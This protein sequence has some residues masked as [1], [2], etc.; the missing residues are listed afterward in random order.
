MRFIP[1]ADAALIPNIIVDGAPAQGTVMT[2]SHWPKSGTPPR[3][4]ADSSA[5]IVFKY[6]ETP[7]A[8]VEV[9]DV[10]NNHFDEDGLVGIFALTLPDLAMRSK[11]LLIDA[12]RAGDFGI[13]RIRD[14]ARVAFVLGAYSEAASS[15]LPRETFDGPYADVA[16]RLYEHILSVL[17]RLITHIG[18]FETFWIDEDRVL[19][20]SESALDRGIVTIEPHDDLD[21]AI[22]GVPEDVAVPHVM[23]LNT[24]TPHT[25][26]IVVRGGSVELRYRYEGWVQF[27]SKKVAPRVDLTALAAELTAEEQKGS[28]IFE[29]VANITPR[30]YFDRPHTSLRVESVVARMIDALRSGASAWDP[31]D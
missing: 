19:D 14:A 29:G 8:H 22:V 28:W 24:R 20:E 16:A 6:L 3:L 25:R 4:R 5:E 31:Y 21:L 15:P 1:Y 2:L 18:D 27:M 12:A 10:S 23:A 7:D 17:P 9:E 11:E 13:D 30:L 26:L